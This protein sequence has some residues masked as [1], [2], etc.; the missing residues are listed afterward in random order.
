MRCPNGSK[1][2]PPKSG[3]CIKKSDTKKRSSSSPVT[4]KKKRCPNGTR[5]NKDGNCIS[6]EI[7]KT[8]ARRTNKIKTPTSNLSVDDGIKKW[9]AE[10]GD[11]D[12]L[13][14]KDIAEIKSGA[15]RHNL[16]GEEV[17]DNIDDYLRGRGI[18]V[19]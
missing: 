1:Q 14:A 6:H 15:K 17:Y 18:L 12:F 10:M 2:H 16:S 8:V 3:I 13:T 5:K 11:E 4:K 19:F 9:L 7:K